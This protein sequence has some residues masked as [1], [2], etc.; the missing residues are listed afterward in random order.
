MKNLIKISI[1]TLGTLAILGTSTLAVTGIVNAPSGLVLREDASKTANPITTVPDKA[2]VNIVEESGEWYKVT[3]ASQEG[4]LFAE[5]VN[6][7]EKIEK[8]DQEQP[9]EEETS[10]DTDNIQTTN[11][12]KVY[13]MPLITSTVINQI[14]PNAEIII[15]KQIKNWSYVSA[16]EIQGWVR[17]YGIENEVQAA[18]PEEPKEE[19]EN[20]SP[21]KPAEEQE[22]LEEQEKPVVE[23]TKKTE[24]QEPEDEE[25][26]QKPTNNAQT[27]TTA[28]AAKG[29]VAVD[30]ATV[31]KEPTTSSEVVT[32]LIKG[33]SFAIKAETE[34]WYKI[35][36]TDIED[37][38]YS[39]YIYKPLVE[40]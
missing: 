17:T 40:I 25:P 33:T 2:E 10:E 6:A 7:T 16:G 1:T 11:K 8:P 4:Y 34:E 27:E 30:S 22:D 29:Y 39:G 19:Q 14:E 26:S 21:E 13:N 23:E 28:S 32:Y 36:Y 20:Q 18:I 37:T 12:L 5:Y 3:Y 35:E 38:V 24:E 15:H 9:A 31:R